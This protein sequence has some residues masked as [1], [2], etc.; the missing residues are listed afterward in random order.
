MYSFTGLQC[1][2]FMMTVKD[3]DLAETH[4]SSR[5]LM[6]IQDKAVYSTMFFFWLTYFCE[7]KKKKTNCEGN[8]SGYTM[9]SASIFKKLCLTFS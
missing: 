1:L 9:L 6:P 5:I 8:S 4:N 3:T 7:G 2:H